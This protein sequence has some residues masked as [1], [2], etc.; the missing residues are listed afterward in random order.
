LAPRMMG[1]EIGY[2]EGLHGSGFEISNPNRK[3]SC[4][5]GS[6]YNY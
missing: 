4:G 2:K 6:S 5:C 1:S 3:S